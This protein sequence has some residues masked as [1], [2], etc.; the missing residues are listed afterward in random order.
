M[1]KTQRTKQI[2]NKQVK[3]IPGNLITLKITAVGANNVGINEF[4]YGIPVLVPN[5][6]L[7]DTV[8]VKILKILTSKKMAI[9]KLIKVINSTPIKQENVNL[10]T[11]NSGTSLD[12][13]INKLGPN[14]TGIADLPNT[15]NN[16]NK[17]IVKKS[18]INVGEKLSVIV[19]RVKKEYAFAVVNTLTTSFLSPKGTEPTVSVTPTNKGATKQLAFKG[20]KFTVVLPK[21]AKRYL[22]HIVFKVANPSLQDLAVNGF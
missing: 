17:L 11:L 10:P 21:K 15:Y 19:T 6:K 9:A 8:Q 12:I 2:I 4:S 7:G 20:T 16:V 14:S 18:F 5:G 1:I 3:L 22:K 13:T